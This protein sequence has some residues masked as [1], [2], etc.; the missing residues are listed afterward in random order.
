MNENRQSE[1]AIKFLNNGVN[2]H[3]SNKELTIQPMDNI[4]LKDIALYHIDEVTFEDKSP[5][6]EALENVLGAMNITGINFI[7]VILGNKAGVSFYFGVAK[8]LTAE[9]PSTLEVYDIGENVLLPSLKGNFRGSS[10][11]YVDNNAKTKIL[12]KINSMGENSYLEGVPGIKEDKGKDTFQGVDRLV[13]VMI[14]D[15]FSVVVI[16]KPVS[17]EYI[18]NIEQNLNKTYSVISPFAKESIQKGTNSND[19]ETISTGTSDSD[20]IGTNNSTSEQ[21][22]TSTN[23]STTDGTNDGESKMT[24]KTTTKGETDTSNSDKSKNTGTSNSTQDGTSTGTSKSKTEGTGTSDSTTIS[25]GTSDSKTNGKSY[26]KSIAKGSGDSETSTIELVRKEVQDWLKYLDETILPRL[27]YGKGKGLFITTT[28]VS[29]TEIGSL[30]KLENTMKAL[31]SGDAGNKVALGS[32]ALS[33]DVIESI[34]NNQDLLSHFRNFQVPKFTFSTPI[35]ETEVFS[36]STLSQRVTDTTAFG[37]NWISAKELSL[38]AGL[39]QKEVVGLSLNEEV[40]FGLNIETISSETE[41][42]KLGNIVLSG[43]V[44]ENVPVYLDKNVLNKHI[45]ITGVTG[46]GKTTTCQRILIDS[47]LPFLVIEPAKTEYRILTKTYKDLL[48]FTLGND[49]VA[50]FRINPFEFLK[51]ES[52]TSRVDMIKASLEANFDMEAAIPQLMESAIYEC[53]KDYGWNISSNK[54]YRFTDPF[55]DGVYAFPT[56]SD[57]IK[58]VDVVVEKQGFDDRLKN[59]YIGSL[60]A[61]LQGLTI[62]SK[63]HMLNCSRSINFV[64]LL[65]KK[66]V[67]EIEDIRSSAE[68]S[69]VIGFVLTNLIESVK[70]KFLENAQFKHITLIEEAHR[71]LSKFSQGDSL[72]KKQSVETFTDMLAEVRKYGES[73]IIADQIP[74]K[75]APEVLKN[76]NTKIVHKIFASDDKEAI[77]NTMALANEQKNY[78]SNLEVGRAVLFTQGYK[79]AVQIKVTQGT[80]TTGELQIPNETIRTNALEYYKTIYKKGLF[81][82]LET[83]EETPT[84]EQFEAFFEITSDDIFHEYLSNYINDKKNVKELAQKLSSYEKQ[85]GKDVILTIFYTYFISPNSEKELNDE[86]KQKVDNLYSSILKEE[87]VTV[88]ERS[89]F[90]SYN[91][92]SYRRK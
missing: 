47:N 10:I 50:P 67:L 2:H 29:S 17:K 81:K 52:I 61:R 83:F 69:L 11:K 64:D 86:I 85:Y 65:D 91:D 76:T 16:A 58:K 88:R 73:L 20:T 42:I 68:K 31:Y 57:L 66:V 23:D 38:L 92:K 33:S 63:G 4:K 22:G 39:P 32:V 82:G 74:G 60:K 14:G 71:L 18:Q 30:L 55:A 84:I 5:R 12:E 70:A 43:Q 72:N 28:F 1:Y 87:V 21:K 26:S 77:G 89:S 54:N 15:E 44:L 37:G 8:D 49:M 6:R 46:S 75:L 34:E 13:D 24:S 40:E 48:I 53:Y 41:K 80:N 3:L 79:K 7:Y 19:S 56:L 62:G 36:R 90:L 25:K 59:D 45:F 27:D 9:T 35:S 51:H 78:L